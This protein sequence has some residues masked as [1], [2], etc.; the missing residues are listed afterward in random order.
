MAS[1]RV[2]HCWAHGPEAADGCSTTCMLLTDHEGPHEWTRDDQIKVT[3]PRVSIDYG[4]Q[5]DD[6]VRIIY[7]GSEW[8]IAAVMP[9]IRRMVLVNVTGERVMDYSRVRWEEYERQAIAVM[10]DFWRRMN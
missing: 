5:H 3:F 2:V 1:E 10:R 9:E 6:H 7:D 4:R 8:K